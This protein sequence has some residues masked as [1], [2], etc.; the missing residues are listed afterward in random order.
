MPLPGNR[1]GKT[2]A[3]SNK[4][5]QSAC[6]PNQDGKPCCSGS[7]CTMA[8]RILILILLLGVSSLASG[9][10]TTP[11]TPTTPKKPS[12]PAA[13]PSKPAPKRSLRP[14]IVETELS[15][16]TGGD[17]NQFG[18]R[19]RLEGSNSGFRWNSRMGYSLN[20]SEYPSGTRINESKTA[21]MRLNSRLEWPRGRSYR[22]ATHAMSLRTQHRNGKISQPHSGYQLLCAGLGRQFGKRFRADLGLGTLT[23]YDRADQRSPVLAATL[24]GQLPIMRNLS[25]DADILGMH[26]LSD[27]AKFRLDSDVSLSYRLAEGLFLRLGWSDTNLLRPVRS[28]REW[29]SALRLSILF[30]Q[31]SMR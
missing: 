18:G 22:F 21:T 14:R 19:L 24:R 8:T 2:P 27:S 15:G 4:E 29:D 11:A 25:L 7:E 5:A 16:S 6:C 13:K 20:V 17:V 30:R 31:S 3:A 28:T 12:K 10:T 23:I 26:P 1:E 9:Q